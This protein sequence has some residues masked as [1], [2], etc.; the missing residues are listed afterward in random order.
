MRLAT[1]LNK[2]KKEGG[3]IF[4]ANPYKKKDFGL[5]TLNVKKFS[6]RRRMIDHPLEEKKSDQVKTSHKLCY[7]KSS[8]NPH[9][10]DL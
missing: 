2:L 10:L 9:L 7:R 1:R 8:S 3:N 6:K 5:R 4:F